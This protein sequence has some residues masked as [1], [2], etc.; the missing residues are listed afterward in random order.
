MSLLCLIM[1][2]LLCNAFCPEPLSAVLSCVAGVNC[3][4]VRDLLRVLHNSAEM[5]ESLVLLQRLCAYVVL[6]R[7]CHTATCE[8]PKHSSTMQLIA[9]AVEEAII[10]LVRLHQRYTF[11]LSEKLLTGPLEVKQGL[12]MSPK[13]G[14][15]VTV[16]RRPDSKAT[17]AAAGA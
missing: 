1:L 2:S 6:A 16:M 17:A 9:A 13:G 15:P 4:Q 14:L 8:A 7:I 3:A 12:T 5:P 11:K 10:A